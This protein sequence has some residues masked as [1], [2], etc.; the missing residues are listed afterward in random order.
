MK[1]KASGLTFLQIGLVAAVAA[2]SGFAGG[3]AHKFF[4]LPAESEPVAHFQETAL[5]QGERLAFVEESSIISAVEK[6]SPA[7]VSIVITKDL[8]IFKRRPFFFDFDQFFSD[9][10]A[11]PFFNNFHNRQN[12]SENEGETQRRKVGGGTGFIFNEKGLVLTNRHVV[13]DE[14]AD[15]TVILQDGSEFSAKVLDRDTQNDIAVLQIVQEGEGR[16][17]P[18]VDFGDSAKI[19]IGQRVIAVGNALAEFENTVTSGVIS[20][21]GR[22]ITASDGWGRGEQLSGLIQTDAAINPGNSGGPLVNLAGEVI[23]INT[24]IANGANGIGFAIPVNDAKSVIESI[25]KHGKIIRPFLGVR[26]LVLNEARAKKLQI[27]VDNG[28]LLV[29]DDSKGEF[30]VVP[31]SPAEKAGLKMKDVILQ[32]NDLE[33][34][35]ENDLRTIIAK[36][37]VGEEIILKVWRSGEELELKVQLEENPG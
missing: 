1:G 35:E 32:V 13:A 36:S 21:T 19:K 9:P 6:I 27:P 12:E 31:G 5:Q 37:N 7:V 4:P 20:A 18:T 3:F 28:A 10:F 24:A 23:G 34:N 11:D 15:F 22:A 33:I 29:G 8:P 16:Q 30:A 17:F 14:S 26:F 2:A 25:Q